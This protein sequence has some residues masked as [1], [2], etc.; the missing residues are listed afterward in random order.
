MAF[1]DPLVGPSGVGGASWD[2]RRMFDAV[3]KQLA[4]STVRVFTSTADR[5]QAI[6]TPK[7][8]QV[9]YMNTGDGTEGVYSYNG[10]AWVPSGNTLDWQTWTPALTAVTTNPT[11]GTGSAVA[12]RYAQV[13]KVVTAQFRITFGTS[14]VAA[15]T[16]GY[17]VSLPVTPESTLTW[18]VGS[19]WAFD[20]S[21]S[22]STMGQ[23]AIDA[24]TS[25]L[26]FFYP[27]T[28]PSGTSSEV[29][30]TTPW[31]W[32][33]SDQIRGTVTYEAA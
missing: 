27:A 16:G 20:S 23:I 7:D 19:Y 3:Q 2:N 8:G 4:T 5:D 31:T 10:S 11:L 32:A 15:G 12:G 21:G 22:A 14:G 30:A 17:R 18:F 28:W 26:R 9:V 33:A 1:V 13:G 25:V 29:A 24:G 6:T